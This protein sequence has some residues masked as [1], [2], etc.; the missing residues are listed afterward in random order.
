MKDNGGR[1]TEQRK[2]EHID[3]CLNRDVAGQGVSTGLD[4]YRFRHNAL[5][6]ID[7]S[8]IR[9]DSSFID[10]E[11]RVPLMISSMTGGTKEAADI[12]RR[13]AQAAERRGWAMG[14][15]SVRAAIE[16]PG[17]VGTFQVRDVAPTIPVLANLGA[18]QLN[19]GYG[20]DQCR[21][22][23]ELSGADGLVLHLNSLQEL[24]Q[25]EGNTNFKGLL[26]KIERICHA[27]AVP[28][29]VKEV[30]WGIR[31]DLAHA[32]H[33]AGAAFIDVAGA[34][35]TSWSQVEK[36]RS[37]DPIRSIAAEAFAGWGL[38]TAECI[39]EV[40]SSL[41]DA[42][43]IGSGGLAN[44][45]DAAKALALGADLAAFGR[46][47]LASAVQSVEQ[48]ERLFE[49]I[50]FELKAVLFATGMTTIQQLKA[51]DVLGRC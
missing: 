16:Q 5:P 30:G 35:G 40:R 12:N 26:N 13:I 6:E 42:F 37:H 4:A 28:V 31:G 46:S 41:P 19:Y 24:F 23:V 20:V 45:V 14:L 44:G 18:V 50:E 33:E 17:L 38:P 47:V 29:G 32:L 10:K 2:A 39:R 25:P 48:L 36:Y 22:A 34:G 27:L 8:D 11:L 3:I 49:R 9:L 7:F 21:Q 43:V 1:Q 51:G 15:G